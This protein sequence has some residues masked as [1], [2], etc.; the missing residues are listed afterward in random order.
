VIATTTTNAKAASASNIAVALRARVLNLSRSDIEI[1]SSQQGVWGVVVETA[2]PDTVASLV[3][4]I[5]GSVSLYVSDGNGCVGCGT[6]REVRAA[7]AELLKLANNVLELT[8]ATTT[9]SLPPAGF[10]RFY[11][12]IGDELR[13]AQT[14]LEEINH[15]EPLGVLFFAGQRVLAAIERAG[16]GQSL[17]HEIRLAL[18]ALHQKTQ[19]DE[20]SEVR[21]TTHADYGD[22][23]CLSVG[24]VV[25]LLR[26]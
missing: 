18:N 19:G 22:E 25:R 11:L 1:P 14:R 15:S 24:N 8:E 3:A 23:Q 2:H 13:S 6:Q 26:T 10:V 12:L 4:L 16:A 7:G 21:D 17:A 9:T 5:D 20:P